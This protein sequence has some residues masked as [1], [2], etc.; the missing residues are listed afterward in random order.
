MPPAKKLINEHGT[1]VTD[2]LQGFIASNPHLRR[3]D[4]FPDIKVVFD[5]SHDKSKVALISGGGSGHEPAHVGYVGSGMLA[6]AVAGEVFASPPAAAVLAAIKAVTGEGGCL[7]VIKNYTG[8]RLHFGLAA[9]QAKSLGFRVETV[10]VGEDAA[11]DNPGMA[12]RRGLAGTVYVH[13]IAGAA[14]AAGAPLAEVAD[15]ARLVASRC[16]TLGLALNKCTLPGQEQGARLGPDEVELGLGIH[17]EPGARAISVA[18]ARELVAVMTKQLVS[19]PASMGL[20]G[21]GARV[22]LLVNNLG[23]TS[24]LELSIVVKEAVKAASEQHQSDLQY[25]A[26]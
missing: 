7:L 25:P 16:V 6:A 21:A 12:G 23:G 3:L 14:A 5:P 13:K 26:D 2:A 11:I 18:P 4:G 22:G 20:F 15:L 1:V 8:D 19:Y 24:P 9:E 10:V 17:N